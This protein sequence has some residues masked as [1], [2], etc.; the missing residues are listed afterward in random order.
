MYNFLNRL[1]SLKM[2]DSDD[3]EENILPDK[4]YFH[5]D[6]DITFSSPSQE[7]TMMHVN[8]RGLI[9]NFSKLEQLLCVMKRK[10][11]LIA[12]S[13]SNLKKNKHKKS[14]IPTFDGYEFFSG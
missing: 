2:P 7:L 5:D 11:D 3:F 9:K 10:P 13:E 6:F 8:I 1:N 4:Y 14:D 12:I